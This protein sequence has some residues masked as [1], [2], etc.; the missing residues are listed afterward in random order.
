MNM[1]ARIP[2][3]V[4]LRPPLGVS[5][6]WLADAT[7]SPVLDLC[8]A[9]NP[10]G[11]PTSVS[12]AAREASL[13]TYPDPTGIAA[14]DRVAACFGTA[15]E[16]VVLGYGAAELLWSCARVLLEPSG[17]VLAI[18]PS[19]AEFSVAARQLGAR[20]VQWRSVER[21]GHAVDLAQ[22]AELMR[23][24]APCVV[25][26]CAPGNPT[27]ASLRVVELHALAAQF[28]EVQFVV[29]QSLLALSDDRA[30]LVRLPAANMVFVRSLSK[31][32]G[33]PGVRAAY[34]LAAPELAE[35]IEAARPAYSTS[36]QAQAVISAAMDEQ[37]FSA[38][39]AQ[40][41]QTDRARL[42]ALLD[43]LGLTYTP[44]VAPFLLVRLARASEVSAEMLERHRIAVCDATPFGLPDHV[45]ICAVDAGAAQQLTAA[46]TEVTQRRGL[47]N[48]REP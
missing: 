39:C 17:T 31:E 12:V 14:R 19:Y 10:Y 48:G 35:R 25:S 27:G 13:R 2:Q 3:R 24:E 41:L 45:R 30:D 32:F 23:L 43:A 37:A 4:S 21:T 29:D 18:A 6:R 44:S 47:Q 22:V 5:D 34:L 9:S 42:A 11:P 16:S 8:T 26:L 1:K 40:T 28:P 15:T 38:E 20:I 33:V 46:L 7:D 36:T